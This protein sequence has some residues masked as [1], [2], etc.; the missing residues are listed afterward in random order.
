MFFKSD[1]YNEDFRKEFKKLNL[2]YFNVLIKGIK[3]L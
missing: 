2:D 3:D 1:D